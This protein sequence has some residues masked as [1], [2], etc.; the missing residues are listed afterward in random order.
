MNMETLI[1]TMNLP[2]VIVTR[3]RLRL[4]QVER[5]MK[6]IWQQDIKIPETKKLIYPMYI[7]G[8][9][10]NMWEKKRNSILLPGKVDGSPTLLLKYTLIRKLRFLR[11]P[12]LKD[13]ERSREKKKKYIKSLYCRFSQVL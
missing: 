3:L 9:R 10:T 1:L 4:S 13:R 7:S 11:I 2:L 6:S 12:S 5:L 8:S